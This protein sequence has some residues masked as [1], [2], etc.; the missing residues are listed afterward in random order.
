MKAFILLALLAGTAT[1]GNLPLPAGYPALLGYSCGGVHTTWAIAG[2]DASGNVKGEVLATTSCSSGGRGARPTLH[3]AYHTL[4]WDLYGGYIVHPYDG[5]SMV[6][7]VATDAYGNMAQVVNNV[8]TL[9]ISSLP[10]GAKHIAFTLPDVTPLSV[11]AAKT[12][13]TALQMLPAVVYEYTSGTV[14]GGTILYTI[15]DIGTMA[16]VG[17]QVQIVAAIVSDNCGVNCD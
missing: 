11:S 5:G 3:T 15:P 9:T 2:F 16:P 14:P 12:A 1:A 10:P 8:P 6:S 7:T 4:T 13:L 17:T